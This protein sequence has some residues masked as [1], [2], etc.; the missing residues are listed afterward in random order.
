MQLRI[1][2]VPKA[3]RNRITGW[4]GDRLK[5]QVMAAPER[6]RANAAVIEM[7]AETLDLPRSACR[8]LSGQASPQKTVEIDGPEAELRAKLPAP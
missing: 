7:L 5:I 4:I 8:I 3:S 6:G 1:K 2:V